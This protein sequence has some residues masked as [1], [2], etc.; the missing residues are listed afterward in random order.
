M[1]AISF[2]NWGNSPKHYITISFPNDLQAPNPADFISLRVST[3]TGDFTFNSPLSVGF[4]KTYD[5]HGRNYV[6]FK[7]PVDKKYLDSQ[8]VDIKILCSTINLN[9][10]VSN[11]Y[12]NNKFHFEYFVNNNVIEYAVYKK[13]LSS[14]DYSL[15]TITSIYFEK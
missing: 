2:F 12:T 10:S 3:K 15:R 14:V 7:F 1:N 6:T 11:N 4:K 8:L 13:H 5:Y 9:N